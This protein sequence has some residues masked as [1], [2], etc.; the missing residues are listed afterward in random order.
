V[1]RILPGFPQTCPKNLWAT[2]FANIFSS[3]RCGMTSKKGLHMILQTL[4]AVF[5]KSNHVGRHFFQTL[6][7]FSDIFTRIPWILA[8]FSGIFPRFSPNQNFWGALAPPSPWLGTPEPGP[9]SLPNRVGS[10]TAVFVI[11]CN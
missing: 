10:I 2:F 3:R 11:E 8:R 7:R 1:R 5:F 6:C 9:Q 4:S